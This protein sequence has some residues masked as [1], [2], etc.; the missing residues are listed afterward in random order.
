MK[1]LLLPGLCLAC[2]PLPPRA[3]AP[4]VSSESLPGPLAGSPEWGGFRGNNSTGIAAHAELPDILDMETNLLWRTEIPRGYSSPTICGE[5]VF[6]TGADKE[7]LSTLCLDRW[8]GEVLWTAS[9]PYDGK[10]PGA[11]SPAAPSPVTDG[12]RVYSVFHHAGLITY[13]MQGQ[14]LWRKDLGAINIP[15]GLATSPLVYKGLLVQMIDQDTGSFLLGLDAASGEERWRTERNNVRHSYSTP[16]M[17][18][19]AEGEAQ[20]IVSGSFQIAGYSLRDGSKLWWV[21]GGAWQTKAVPVV[22]GD[23]CIVNSFMLSTSEMG[24]PKFSGTFE[25]L[26]ELRDEN[27]N[28]FLDREE[29]DHELIQQIWFI[30]DLDGD[31]RLDSVDWDYALATTRALGGLFAIQLGGSGN[32]TDTHVRWFADDRRGLPDI[33]SPLVLDGTIYMIKRGGIFTALDAATGKVLQRGRVGESDAYYASPVAAGKR[34]LL[35]SQSGQLLILDADRGWEEVSAGSVD[36]EV[37]STPALAGQHVLVRS[38]SALY[39]FG[40]GPG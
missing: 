37:W 25:E 2:A 20:I 1:S 35:A 29:W 12:E 4:A 30:L 8:S 22:D 6:I 28:G 36:E 13:D 19:P 32:V 7:Q 38:L 3:V 39:C 26:L 9:L 18:T 11:N 16:T 40:P 17:Y 24:I 27:G 33:P 23:L 15:H 10:R 21:D 34:I 31:S 5:R 14:E